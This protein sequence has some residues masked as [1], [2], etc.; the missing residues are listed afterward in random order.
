MIVQYLVD[1]RGICEMMGFNGRLHRRRYSVPI[2]EQ[3]SSIIEKSQMQAVPST[4]DPHW[5]AVNCPRIDTG[6]TSSSKFA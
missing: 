3:I 6:R 5:C 2:L 1:K 4:M